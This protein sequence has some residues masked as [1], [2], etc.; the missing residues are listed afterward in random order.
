[1]PDDASVDIWRLRMQMPVERAAM[2]A[3][4]EPL[5]VLFLGPTEA[6]MFTQ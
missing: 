3:F 6:A 1:M 4:D 2:R 5:S